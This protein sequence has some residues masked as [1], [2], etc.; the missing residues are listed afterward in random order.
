MKI[1]EKA[2][3]EVYE[4][5]S[6]RIRTG[7]WPPGY[8]L[9]SEPALAEEF[10]VSRA[11]V[12]EALQELI[13]RGCIKREQG[14]G[15]YVLHSTIDYAIDD[16]MSITHLLEVNGAV[17]STKDIEVII[18]SA[19]AEDAESLHISDLEPVYTINRTRCADG[20]AVVYDSVV[21]PCRFLPSPN[22]KELEGSLFKILDESGIR[23][24]QGIGKVSIQTA[25]DLMSAKMS[26][27]KQQP[28]LC[29]FSVL[30]DQN[31]SA[32]MV[33]RDYYTD[34]IQFPIR[35]TRKEFV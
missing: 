21:I 23:I 24:T 30:Y 14:R 6:S 31:G 5:I 34:R 2:S 13:S 25:S 18:G 28:L 29:M 7:Q 20:V 8:K 4:T 19:S 16:L 22:K 3:N 15:T 9:P 33:S 27:D 32:I 17:A 10:G 35:R 26:I 1:K 12:R 11:T